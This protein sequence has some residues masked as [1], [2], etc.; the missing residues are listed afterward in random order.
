MNNPVVYFEIPVLDM[1][2]AIQFYSSVFG[3]DF[4]TETIHGNEMAFFPLDA[5]SN[6]ISGGLAKGEIYKPSKEG[7]LIYFSSTDIDQTLSKVISA[8]GKTLF[9]KTQAGEYGFV[10]EFE[11]SEG[12]RIGLSQN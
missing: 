8:G 5:K 4:T 7:S 10:A 12:N 2:R 11:D 3:F 1:E 6:G 9:P